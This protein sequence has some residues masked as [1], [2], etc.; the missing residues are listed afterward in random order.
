MNQ[1]QQWIQQLPKAE[2]HLHIEGTLEPELLFRLADRHRINLSYKDIKACRA[3]YNFSDLQSFLYLYYQGMQVLKTEDD[4]YELTLAYLQRIKQENV[5]HVEIFFDPQAHTSRGI[6][7]NTVIQGIHYA[8]QM[9][10]KE[11]QITSNLILCFLRDQSVASAYNTLMQAKHYHDWII[12]VGLDSAEGDYPPH[13]FQEVFTEARNLG[14]KTVAHAGEEGPAAFI[15]EALDLLKVSRIDHGVRC[16]EDL[17]LVKRLV[18]EQIPL[19]V[20]PLSNVKLKVVD[21]MQDHPIKTMLEQGLCVTINS[22]DP[23]YFGGYLT[24]NLIQVVEAF[25]LSKTQV[26]QL[27]ENSFTASFIDNTYRQQ[28][29][30]EL[31]EGVIL[32]S[33]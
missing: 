33:P 30:T 8:L 16:L 32:N 31:H 5:K 2:L 4:F 15:T 18:N 11:Y 28:L 3:A 14:F 29:L 19:T 1:L 7:F 12:G 10:T 20:C 24:D 22:D 23:A 13:L 26:V 9:A 21:H 6:D 25:D 17:D 27:L